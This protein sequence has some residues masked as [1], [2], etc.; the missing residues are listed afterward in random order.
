VLAP[1]PESTAAFGLP[2]P[3]ANAQESAMTQAAGSAFAHKGEGIG[4]SIV[5]GLCELLRAS[6]EIESQVGAG[7]LFRIRLSIHWQ[8]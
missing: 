8:H 5:K 4:L 2:N 1:A 7:T 6:L 3:E